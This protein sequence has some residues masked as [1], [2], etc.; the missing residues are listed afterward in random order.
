MNLA[1][2]LS[3]ESINNGVWSGY[4]GFAID[5]VSFIK[6]STIF[7]L[8]TLNGISFIIFAE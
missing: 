7:E 2:E 8:S 3:H 4:R 1:T 5:L 6:P